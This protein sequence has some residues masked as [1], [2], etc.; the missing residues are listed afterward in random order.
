MA[1]DR[2]AQGHFLEQ[3]V[4]SV[5]VPVSS[6]QFSCHGDTSLD[7]HLELEDCLAKFTGRE[8]VALYSYGFA[9]I[10]SA[11]PAY[12]KRRDIIFWY[13]KSIHVLYMIILFPLALQR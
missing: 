6:S 13:M 8:E 2:V 10:S 3:W 7:V 5:L 11:I 1:W 12:S 4:S 9:V